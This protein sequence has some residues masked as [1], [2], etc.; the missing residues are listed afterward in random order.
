MTIFNNVLINYLIDMANFSSKK[1]NMQP[2]G[3]LKHWCM[4]THIGMFW[5][6][7]AE[8]SYLQKTDTSQGKLN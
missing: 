1:C 8:R 3:A 2:S 5:V 4:N 7:T 6:R